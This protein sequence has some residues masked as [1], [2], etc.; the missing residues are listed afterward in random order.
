[1]IHRWLGYAC[2][3]MWGV[4]LFSA[5]TFGWYFFSTLMVG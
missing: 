2:W 3:A 5:A 1:M 4:L